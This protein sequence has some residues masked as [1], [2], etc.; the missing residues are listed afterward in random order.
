MTEAKKQQ[1]RIRAYF[2][3]KK[4]KELRSRNKRSFKR[5]TVW[6]GYE[7]LIISQEER[8]QIIE[9]GRISQEAYEI[10]MGISNSFRNS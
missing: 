5:Q 6:R 1:R 4:Q 8:F 2:L 3:Q 7:D 10:C 9:M